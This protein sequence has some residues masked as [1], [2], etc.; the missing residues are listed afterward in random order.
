M[1]RHYNFFPER[2]ISKNVY[3]QKRIYP[4]RDIFKNRYITKKI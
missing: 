3:N 1:K 4:K 2:D